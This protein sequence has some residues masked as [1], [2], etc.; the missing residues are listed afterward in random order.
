MPDD[1]VVVVVIIIVLV[2]HCMLLCV[3]KT[4]IPGGVSSCR[5]TGQLVQHGQILGR[6]V[7]VPLGSGRSGLGRHRR[8]RGQFSIRSSGGWVRGRLGKVLDAFF[9]RCTVAVVQVGECPC[10]HRLSKGQSRVDLAVIVYARSSSKEVLYG[11]A[12]PAMARRDGVEEAPFVGLIVPQSDRETVDYLP[13][14]Y[15]KGHRN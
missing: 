4:V 9:G 1:V 13:Q 3:M 14:R 10:I 5:L 6:G 15:R 8:H 2:P 7:Q 12:Q 11:R